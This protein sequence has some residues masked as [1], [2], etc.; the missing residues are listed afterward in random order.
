M[1]MIAAGKVRTHRWTPPAGSSIKTVTVAQICIAVNVTV[2]S[3]RLRHTAAHRLDD[4]RDRNAIATF[5]RITSV[6]MSRRIGVDDSTGRFQR[7]S[8]PDSSV[9]VSSR[10]MSWQRETGGQDG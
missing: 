7:G 9:G 10:L 2:R 5:L 1:A 4:R 3:E 6:T 8:R